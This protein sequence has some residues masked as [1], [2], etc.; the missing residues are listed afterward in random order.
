MEQKRMLSNHSSNYGASVKCQIDGGGTS[1]ASGSASWDGSK[2]NVNITGVD[3]G[4]TVC[5]VLF[6]FQKLILL[7]SGA[8]V[9]RTIDE[10]GTYRITV[11]WCCWYTG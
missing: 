9:T 1:N 3:T 11:T 4:R 7:Y 5:N 8:E 6:C 10:A 2:W